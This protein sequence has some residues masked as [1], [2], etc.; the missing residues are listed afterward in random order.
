M[1]RK[2]KTLQ[3]GPAVPTGLRNRW[4]PVG[5]EGL[6]GLR[7]PGLAMAGSAWVQVIVRES[8]ASSIRATGVVRC[9]VPC[10]VG[11]GTDPSVRPSAPLPSDNSRA[12]SIY[13]R[14][15]AATQEGSHRSTCLRQAPGKAWHQAGRPLESSGST[16]QGPRT[17]RRKAGPAPALMP[18]CQTAAPC[19]VV[20]LVEP[21]T[22]AC[23]DTPVPARFARPGQAAPSERPCTRTPQAGLAEAFGRGRRQGAPLLRHSHVTNFYGLTPVVQRSVHD[24]ASLQYQRMSA[25]A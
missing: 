20:R 10:R 18:A 6:D 15:R 24:I 14:V 3:S 2:T 22:S 7:P 23:G 17:S 19:A 11:V 1:V 21:R 13:Y 8:G 9:R 5:V 12:P 25:H 16:R 4:R